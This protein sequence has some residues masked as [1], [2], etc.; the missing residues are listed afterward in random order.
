[1]LLN[2]QHLSAITGAHLIAPTEAVFSLP[3]KVLQFG[4]GV[5]LRGLPDYYIDKANRN[6]IFNGRI[7]VVKSTATG[8]IDGF[9]KQDNLYTVCIKGIEDGKLIEENIINSS[10]SRVLNAAIDWNKILETA[11]NENIQVIISNTTEAG[12]TPSKDSLSDTP[13][14]SFPGKL[15]AVLVKRYETCGGNM[16]KGFVILPTELISNNG[17]TLKRIILQ[18]ATYNNISEECITWIGNANFFC[19]TL[20]DRIVPGSYLNKELDYEDTLTIM[21]EPFGLWAIE[22][23]SPIVKQKLSFAKISTGIILTSAIEKY[24]EIKL[25]LLNGS[26]SLACALAILSGFETVKEALKDEIFAGF[27]QKLLLDEIGTAIQSEAITNDD[28]KDFGKKVLDRFRNPFLEHKWTSIA[29][30]YTEKFKLR[31]LPIL[32]QYYHRFHI[33]P[34]NFALGFS[35][36]VQLMISDQDISDKWQEKIRNIWKNNDSPLIQLLESE[37]IWGENLSNYKGLE[38]KIANNMHLFSQKN[39]FDIF[40]KTLINTTNTINEK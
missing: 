1:M 12:I 6:N 35:A 31:C 25:R 14:L 9:D 8:G 23:S 10:I 13:P 22:T 3:E 36:Y 39:I 16:D 32:K 20:V 40:D 37:D 15:L 26:H 38:K 27:V 30:N 5:L 28:I 24:K 34:D 11:A 2:R 33:I 17:D 18:L 21:A 29:V 4:T 7:V 19:N